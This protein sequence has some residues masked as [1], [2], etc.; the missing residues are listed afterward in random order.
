MTLGAPVSETFVYRYRDTIS[1]CWAL[2]VGQ[3]LRVEIGLTPRAPR[4][5]RRLGLEWAW[6]CV[7]EPWRLVPRYI[8]AAAWFPCAVGLDLARLRQRS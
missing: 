6:R 1:P 3:A 5:W 8:R 4:G 2:C 7:W